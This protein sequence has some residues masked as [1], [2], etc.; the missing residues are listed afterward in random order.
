M[1]PAKLKSFPR[2]RKHIFPRICSGASRILQAA[3]ILKVG[4]K[5]YYLANFLPKAKEIGPKGATRP[6]RPLPDPPMM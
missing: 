4:V 1:A 2:L 3:P 5:S 6:W